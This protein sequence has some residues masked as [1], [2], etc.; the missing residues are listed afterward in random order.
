MVRQIFTSEGTK[1]PPGPPNGE[2]LLRGNI[3]RLTGR[4]H[5]RYD[6]SNAKENEGQDS[7][8]PPRTLATTLLGH[9]RPEQESPHRD[10]IPAQLEYLR[11]LHMGTAYIAPQRS[12][13]S[14]STY[15]RRIYDVLLTLMEEDAQPI[16]VRIERLWPDRDWAVV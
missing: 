14:V 3:Y 6:L 5:N 11:Q 12:E 4:H 8:T 13:E 9:R 7:E 16:G 10:R 2:L 1:P 15:R